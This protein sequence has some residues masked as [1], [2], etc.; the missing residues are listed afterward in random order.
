M[1]VL[2]K[3]K[4]RKA[5]GLCYIAL[6]VGVIT[7]CAWISL[8][9]GNIPVT[10]QTFGV[11]FAAGFL[12]CKRGVAAVGVYLALGFCG[13]PVFAGFTG[14]ISKLA[15]PTGGYLL[16]F[17]PMAFFVGLFADIARRIKGKTGIFLMLLGCVIGVLVCHAAGVGW[18]MLYSLQADGTANFL[19][20]LLIC[21]LPYLP[22]DCLKI[23]FAVFFTVKLKRL[24][25]AQKS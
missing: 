23:V 16:G 5:T 7:V 18:F 13:V 20:A 21:V 2:Q 17:L 9:I 22:Y 3:V 12:G 8:Y 1:S 15:M 11:C 25:G 10:L 14:G 4:K 19:A 24:I 6:F